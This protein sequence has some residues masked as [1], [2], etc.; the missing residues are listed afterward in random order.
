M[1][2]EGS[3]GESRS[4]FLLVSLTSW[5]EGAAAGLCCQDTDGITD[6]KRCLGKALSALICELAFIL[7]LC[8]SNTLI[9]HGRVGRGVR[10]GR[11]IRRKEE[12]GLDIRL[13]R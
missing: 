12:T 1:C 3:Q 5:L 7:H 2:A 10:D 9:V 4:I 8:A 13:W 6:L 11:A